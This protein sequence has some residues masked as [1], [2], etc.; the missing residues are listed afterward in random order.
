MNGRIRTLTKTFSISLISIGDICND[1]IVETT[2][3][4][5]TTTTNK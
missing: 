4:S 3:L 1:E 2:Y 5:V